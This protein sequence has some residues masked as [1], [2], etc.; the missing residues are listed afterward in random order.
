[1]PPSRLYL[2]PPHL[3]GHELNYVAKA[4]A[5][6]WIAPAGPHLPAFEAELAAALTGS[7]G[8]APHVVALSS[9]TA[10]LHLALRLVGVAAGDEVICPTFTFAATANPIVYQGAVPV[11]V[12]SEPDTWNLDPDLL[13]EAL[14][15]RQRRGKRVRAIIVVHLYGMPARLP[16]LLAVAEEF[17]V[18]VIEDAAEALGSTIYNRPVGT[19]APLGILSFNGNKIITTSGGGALLAADPAAAERALYLATQA[20]DGATPYYHHAEVGYNY[21]LSNVLAGIGRGQLEDLEDRVKGRRTLF[22]KYAERLRF[23]DFLTFG[24]AEPVG[25]TSN[26]WLTTVLLDPNLA[27]DQ[28]PEHLRQHLETFNIETRP[29]WKPLHLQPAFA[30]APTYGGSVA[31]GLFARGLCLPSG[32]GM[33][34][35]DLDRVVDAILRF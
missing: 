30:D 20:K 11:F 33:R 14:L 12:D 25:F 27:A 18:P 16:E 23:L 7:N 17:G 5:D 34:P 9:G 26:R 3:G 6:G 29:F 22:R 10:A 4:L 24:P 35:A 28:S 8:S 32:N 15:D 1:M 13:R 31:E 21:R 19:W 2:S